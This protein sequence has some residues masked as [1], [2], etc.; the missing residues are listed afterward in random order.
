M[1]NEVRASTSF[2][3]KGSA[4]MRDI[5]KCKVTEVINV[6][7]E[8]TK[9]PHIYWLMKRHKVL[10]CSLFKD[11]V[12]NSDKLLNNSILVDNELK[13]IEKEMILGQFKVYY[14]MA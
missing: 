2:T 13:R 3:T 7:S 14:V 11:T 4:L 12:S 5:R 9:R 6:K 1:Y 10:T 8:V